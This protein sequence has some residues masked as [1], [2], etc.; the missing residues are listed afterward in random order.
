M[1]A[2]NSKVNIRICLAERGMDTLRAKYEPGMVGQTLRAW[3]I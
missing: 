1:E 2:I 3:N